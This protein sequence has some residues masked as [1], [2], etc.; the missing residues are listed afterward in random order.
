[1]PVPI[2]QSSSV[3]KQDEQSAGK[4]KIYFDDEEHGKPVPKRN[5]KKAK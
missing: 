2:G 1:V 3:D 5:P 4:R